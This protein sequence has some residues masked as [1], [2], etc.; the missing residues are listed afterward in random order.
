LGAEAHRVRR[1]VALQGV[2]ITAVGVAAGLLTALLSTWVL[3]S[4][5]FGVGTLH[6]PTFAGM[7]AVV[8]AVA[9]LA[10]YIPAR[11][12]SSVDP[13]QSLRTE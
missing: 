1:M 11:R 4:L 3:D 8:L 9:F 5:L 6:V 2:R 12:A 10:S 13:M 7:S